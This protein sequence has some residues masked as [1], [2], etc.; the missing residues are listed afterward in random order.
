MLGQ[1]FGEGDH[2]VAQ[3]EHIVVVRKQLSRVRAEHGSAA[4]LQSDHEPAGPA[5]MTI[6][7]LVPSRTPRAALTGDRRVPWL[8]PELSFTA[9]RYPQLV[10]Q[11]GVPPYVRRNAPWST[12]ADPRLRPRSATPLRGG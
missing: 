4:R 2:V 6:A 12:G 1:E 9:D 11:P 10:P 8:M 3:P 5:E 7:A